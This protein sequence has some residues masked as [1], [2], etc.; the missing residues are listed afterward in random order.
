MSNLWSLD[1]FELFNVGNVVSIFWIF[2]LNK[3][4]TCISLDVVVEMCSCKITSRRWWLRKNWSPCCWT[5]KLTSLRDDSRHFHTMIISM[6][7]LITYCFLELDVLYFSSTDRYWNI[8]SPQIQRWRIRTVYVLWKISETYP[9]TPLLMTI[10]DR[11]VFLLDESINT[12][13]L[14]LS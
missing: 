1:S 3:E 4:K 9:S 13:I 10:F 7:Y 5:V 8:R 11:V 2:H 6:D 12:S 14:Y